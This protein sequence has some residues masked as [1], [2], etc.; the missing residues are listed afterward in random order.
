[1]RF[2]LVLLLAMVSGLARAAPVEI[3][4]IRI[5]AAPD[6]TRVVFDLSGPVEHRLINLSDPFRTVIDIDSKRG[7]TIP[8]GGSRRK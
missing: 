3:E 7:G 2:Y 6:G 1:M 5:W 4:H 8:C